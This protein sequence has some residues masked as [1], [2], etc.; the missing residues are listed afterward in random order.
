[1]VAFKAFKACLGRMEVVHFALVIITTM[2][3]IVATVMVEVVMVEAVKAIIV[4][5]VMTIII[6]SLPLNGWLYYL[7]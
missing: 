2:S 3:S 5:L 1:M 7:Q 4:M 6:Q